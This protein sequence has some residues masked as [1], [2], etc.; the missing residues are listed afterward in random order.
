V[1][2]VWSATAAAPIGLKA[3]VLYLA[4]VIPACVAFSDQEIWS[5]EA[6]S[7]M[8][9]GGHDPAGI[10]PGTYTSESLGVFY[11]PAP[12][13]SLSEVWQHAASRDNHTPGHVTFISMLVSAGAVPDNTEAVRMLNI[14]L[15]GLFVFAALP[16]MREI[17]RPAEWATA[18]VLVLSPF[19][20]YIA[21]EIRPYGLVLALSLTSVYLVMRYRRAIRWRWLWLAA[22]LA[23]NVLG[24]LMHKLFVGVVASEIAYLGLAALFHRPFSLGPVAETAVMG[25]ATLA[26]AVY[27]PNLLATSPNAGGYD[28]AWLQTS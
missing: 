15:S 21:R 27:I 12:G 25:A 1:V 3:L 11:D 23:V 16:L 14:A 22:V 8:L 19:A 20:V 2:R 9:M 24:C 13:V 4:F 6:I 5:D 10:T 18:T 7:L 26:V 28:T 17:G